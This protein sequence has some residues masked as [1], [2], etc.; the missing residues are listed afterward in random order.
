MKNDLQSKNTQEAAKEITLVGTKQRTV[1][2]SLSK[3]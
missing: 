3:T 2:Q 1:K